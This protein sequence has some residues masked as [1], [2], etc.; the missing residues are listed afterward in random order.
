MKSAKVAL[1]SAACLLAL[2]G[3]A[4]AQTPAP[5]APVA[6]AAAAAR[7]APPSAQDFTRAPALTQVQL[8]PDGRH[9]LAVTSPDGIQVV[10][11]VWDTAHL[12][13][14]PA[15]FGASQ[16]RILNARFIKNDRI[17]VT[18]IQPYTFGGL[19]N[20]HITKQYITDLTGSRF[21]EI[22][23]VS[24]SGLSE[25]EQ[26]Q[27]AR[28]TS[29]IIDSL[30]NDPQNVLVLDAR[31]GTAGDI[32]RVNVYTRQA[33]RVE[34]ATDRYTSPQTDL[35]GRVRARQRLDYDNGRV[36][37][38]QYIANP[39]TGALE[40]HFRWYASDRQPM[41]IVG[42][43]PDANIVYVRSTRD[44]DRAAIYEYDIRQRRILEPA[45]EHR[46]F[47][48]TDVIQSRNDADNGRVLGFSYN[49]WD[50]QIYWTDPQ[51]AALQQSINTALQVRTEPYDWTDIASGQ[52]VRVPMPVDYDARIV[53][54]SRDRSIFVIERSGPSR[55]PEYFILRASDGRLQ[56][57]GRSYPNL[58]L[59]TL[60]HT[61]LI[62]YAARDGLMIPALLT[63]PDP[64]LFG[65]GPYPA[66]VIPHGGPW[67]RDEWGW[68]SSGWPQYF[69]SRGFA[70]L[71]PEFRGSQGWGQRLWRAG[72]GEWGQKM[73]DDKDD[74]VRWMISQHIADPQRVAMFGYS[75]G[76][77]AALVAAIRPNGLYQCA[78]SGAGAGDLATIQ[79]ST[80][81]SR[82]LREFQ[83]PTIAG[84]DPLQRAGDVS[85][86][87]MIYSGTRDTTVD[88]EQ[89]RLFAARLRAAG[90]PFRMLEIPDMGHQFVTWG[91]NDG[92]TQ[93]NA[94]DAFL[95]NECGP[96]GI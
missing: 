68:D 85:I 32:V 5:A 2:Q 59:A 45:F 36:F 48:A 55:P 40:E 47:E 86:P 95:H 57:L 53:S 15:V 87:L 77:Y 89:S 6:A 25:Q 72:D 7:P 42:F 75:Y 64:A 18:A 54:W 61:R 28:S 46:L 3:A 66:L 84:L 19:F 58:N 91:P 49:A 74:G 20:G 10:V 76:G 23:T 16:M 51:L 43:T 71:Q 70:I 31:P 22:L 92:A 82:Y 79:R 8:S 12:D 93:L 60:G 30:P 9:L 14:R 73:Q 65:P 83:R 27:A 88:I 13:Q 63:T 33:E 41:E 39:D 1:M 44:R 38:A 17:A 96:G 35:Q 37:L 34:R 52:R 50:G 67:S 4:V 80:S 21:D 69:A 11:S 62:Q 78:I 26:Q 29:Q 81:D 90:K 94:I 56:P 24:R